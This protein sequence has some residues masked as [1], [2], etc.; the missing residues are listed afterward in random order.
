MDMPRHDMDQC[1]VLQHLYL[2]RD[3]CVHATEEDL[4]SHDGREVSGYESR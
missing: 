4:E 2:H 3:I 1:F